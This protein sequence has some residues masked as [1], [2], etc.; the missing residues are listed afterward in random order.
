MSVLLE[1][2]L[3]TLLALP[4]EVAR[5]DYLEAQ[6]GAIDDIAGAQLADDL[7]AQADHYLRSEI[8]TSF[9]FARLLIYWGERTHN[10]FHRALGLRAE[11][12]A[13]SIG[14]GR[15]PEALDT[16]NQA[17][18]IYRAHG[19]PLDEAKAQ[20]GKVWPLA[21]LGQYD[22]ALQCGE[23]IA[24]VLEAH[25]DW[26]QLATIT[27][28][29]GVIFGRLGQETRALSQVNRAIDAFERIGAAE[30]YLALQNRA[31]I[32]RNLGQFDA[33]ISCAVE[34]EG[35]PRRLAA[36]PDTFAAPGQPQPA[37]RSRIIHAAQRSRAD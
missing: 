9:Q 4:D 15:Y 26:R 21:A 36:L 16:Y 25:Q 32:L 30:L 18:A 7:K 27:M 35:R 28:N 2:L 3:A 24:Q 17:A 19:R 12:N 14:L 20:I 5:R 11:A 6:V 23:Q 34:F 37:T 13:L 22:E 33:S 31:E 29:L 10:D 8:Q 1:P